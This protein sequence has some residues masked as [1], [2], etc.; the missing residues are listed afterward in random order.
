VAPDA[1]VD[2]QASWLA[3]VFAAISALRWAAV[4]LI[5]LLALTTCAA[6]L[7]AARTALNGHRDTIDIVHLLGGTDSQIA[8]IFQRSMALD[9][10]VGGAVGLVLG[11]GAVFALGR[12]FAALDTGMATAAGLGWGGWAALALVPVA[13]VILATLTARA[14]VL[15]ALRRML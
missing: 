7:L 3:P 12:S 15:G 10:A 8:R 6:V 5:V 4:G 1:R 14:A 9:A 11:A 2:A 13:A